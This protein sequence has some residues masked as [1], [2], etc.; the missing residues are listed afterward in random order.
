MKDELKEYQQN[1]FPSA[2]QKLTKEE[3]KA[4]LL[5]WVVRIGIN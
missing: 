3:L 4:T 5:K 2:P 1:F